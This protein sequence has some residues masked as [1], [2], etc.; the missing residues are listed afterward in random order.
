MVSGITLSG[1]SENVAALKV[2]QEVGLRALGNLKPILE[3]C[4]TRE[5]GVDIVPPF[6]AIA[7]VKLPAE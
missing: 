5:A 7:L 2:G 6:N 4:T 1:Q 3:R